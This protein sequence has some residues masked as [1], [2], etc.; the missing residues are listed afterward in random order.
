[1]QIE[2]KTFCGV[3]YGYFVRSVG[4]FCEPLIIIFIV[5]C[6]FWANVESVSF[7]Y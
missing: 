7:Y 1:M 5:C 4:Y 3:K 6:P 2:Q